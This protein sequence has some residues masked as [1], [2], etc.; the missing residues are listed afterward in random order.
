MG[1]SVGENLKVYR[2]RAN[3]SMD[4]AGKLMNMSAPAILKYER[5]KIVASLEKLEQ[6]AK[7]YNTTLDDLL[8]VNANYEIKFTNFKCENKTA[9]IKQEKI[10]NLLKRKIDNYFELLNLSQIELHNK[11]GV[12]IINSLDEAESLATKLRIFLAL[13]LDEPIE[14]LVHLLENHNIVIITIPK[15]NITK[16][17]IG[18]Y[19]IVNNVPIIA[20]PKADNGYE[21]RYNIAK[22]LGELLIVSNKKKDALTTR[23]ALSLLIPKSSLVKEFGSIRTKIDFKEIE[24]F[25]SI[26]KVGYKNIVKRLENCEI[27]TPSNAKYTNIYIN[28]NNIKENTY[29]EEAYNYDKMLAKLYAIGIIKEKNKYE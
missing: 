22:F 14:N 10:K 25:S 5:N 13:P 15:N 16:E 4:A 6:F 17:F 29:I 3:L 20:V 19:E 21:Q 7:A 24:I 26:Y 2:L 27:I 8:D 12:H 18:F 28:K 9:Q 11:F 23:F 1:K